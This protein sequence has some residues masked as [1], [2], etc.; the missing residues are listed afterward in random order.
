MEIE[1]LTGRIQALEFMNEAH[2][3]AIEE[4]D[5]HLHCSMM[6]LKN[7]KYEILDLQA[8]IRVKDQEIAA[9]QRRYVGYLSDEDKNNGLSIIAKNKD[10]AEY[11]LYI[12]IRTAW[13]QKAQG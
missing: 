6:T 2:R 4:E 7:R 12:Y 10:E 1:S 3:Q 8:E 11:N 5:A 9:L 13:L